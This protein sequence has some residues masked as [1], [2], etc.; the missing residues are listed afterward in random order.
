MF[1]CIPKSNDIKPNSNGYRKIDSLKYYICPFTKL[2]YEGI[3]Y[4]MEK[5]SRV[6]ISDDAIYIDGYYKRYYKFWNRDYKIIGLYYS[7][8]I[9]YHQKLIYA[10]DFN[11]ITTVA[12]PDTISVPCARYL[13]FK[14]TFNVEYNIYPWGYRIYLAKYL[15]NYQRRIVKTAYMCLMR[16]KV[17]KCL[18]IHIFKITF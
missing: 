15:T 1:I 12:A 5:N 3:I 17:V 18:I 11:T 16:Y 8:I 6:I 14:T 7:T 4:L 9:C 13:S 10:I 2:R